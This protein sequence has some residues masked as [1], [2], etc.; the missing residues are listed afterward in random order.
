L[1]TSLCGSVPSVTLWFFDRYLI[2]FLLPE[3]RD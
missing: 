3:R 1:N 2:L